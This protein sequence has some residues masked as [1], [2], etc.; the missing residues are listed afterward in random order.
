MKTYLEKIHE[1]ELYAL[2]QTIKVWERI[3]LYK[4]ELIKGKT[5]LNRLKFVN[6][7]STVMNGNCILC[8]HYGSCT[9]CV[10][11]SCY[12]GEAIYKNIQNS[13]TRADGVMLEL[14]IE[15]LINKCY[16]RIRELTEIY[17]VELYLKFDEEMLT[18]EK[19]ALTTAIYMYLYLQYHTEIILQYRSLRTIKSSLFAFAEGWV[20]M[21][22]LCEYY[23]GCSNG[24]PLTVCS[25][26]SAYDQICEGCREDDLHKFEFGCATIV[27]LC[28]DRL[29]EL[30]EEN[31]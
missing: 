30:E 4:E 3:L 9:D 10:L 21:C 23:Y 14:W 15:R 25:K 7:N 13:I 29:E 26:G 27:R 12:T 28:Y 2:D 8:E 18:D 16:A 17:R 31:A 5:T 22:P 20:S 11:K 24:C 1:S 6:A 19:I